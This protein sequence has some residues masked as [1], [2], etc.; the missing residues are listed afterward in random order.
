MGK[1]YC[2]E[3]KSDPSTQNKLGSNQ[4]SRLK[5][6]SDP[7]RQ[8]K[9]IQLSNSEPPLGRLGTYF[10]MNWIFRFFF[11]VLTSYAM[12]WKQGLSVGEPQLSNF[13][14]LNLIQQN[15]ILD[16]LE[17][18]SE[19]S[20]QKYF[21]QRCFQQLYHATKFNLIFMA[22]FLSMINNTLLNCIES[23]RKSVLNIRIKLK[24]IVKLF[25][26]KLTKP[27]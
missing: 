19:V 11:A 20:K 8:G 14:K 9:L 2:N 1:K 10:Y 25:I 13:Q 18:Q 23:R 4:Q 17:H 21:L 27:F 26:R 15:L 7:E 24:F 5:V 22:I 16:Q 6:E 3:N 12:D